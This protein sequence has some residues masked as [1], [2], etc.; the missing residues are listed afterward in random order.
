M[1]Q[2]GVSKLRKDLH[3][4]DHVMS[5]EVPDHLTSVSWCDGDIQQLSGIVREEVMKRCVDQ[6]HIK[7]KQSV[8]RTGVEQ[9]ADVSVIFKD[10]K[11][12]EKS[13]TLIDVPFDSL[14][15]YCN[16]VF[17]SLF[18]EGVLK[19]KNQKSFVLHDFLARVPYMLEKTRTSNKIFDGFV[20]V[21]MLD[22][23]DRTWPDLDCILKT[24]R[25]AI[26]LSERD[27]IKK[28]FPKLY[29]LT[30]K[31]GYV[32][33][34]VYDELNFPLDMAGNKVFFRPHGIEAEWMQRS[35]QLT[36]HF[37]ILARKD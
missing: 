10:L 21:G 5:N 9:M 31:L 30:M 1:F 13:T 24:K 37:Q 16:T 12:C 11:A 36:S 26:S 3:G 32:P 25:K 29:N 2:P 4:F 20:S 17:K 7:N 14:S 19:L 34:R 15:G 18:N 33:E 23:Q 27:F 35:K 22:K 8:K 6:K 28:C